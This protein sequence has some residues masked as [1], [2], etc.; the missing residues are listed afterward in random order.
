MAYCVTDE[1]IDMLKDDIL[2]PIIGNAYIEDPAERKAAIRP[3]A[4]EAITDADAE[5][6]G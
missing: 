6:D 3:L 5:I 1:V 4:D 2:N